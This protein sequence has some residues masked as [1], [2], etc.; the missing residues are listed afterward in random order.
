MAS[1]ASP[2]L[3]GLTSKSAALPP[4]G[5][6]GEPQPSQ[7]FDVFYEELLTQLME[8]GEFVNKS[9]DNYTLILFANSSHNLIGVSLVI[10]GLEF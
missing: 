7:L 9:D 2:T 1:V 3:P 4:G 6:K 8:S 10:V 5:L